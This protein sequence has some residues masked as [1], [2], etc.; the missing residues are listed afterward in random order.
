MVLQDFCQTGTQFDRRTF[1]S[2]THIDIKFS[3]FMKTC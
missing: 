3:Q 2:A 1:Y